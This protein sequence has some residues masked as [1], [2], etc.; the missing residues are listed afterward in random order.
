MSFFNFNFI[1]KHQ[2]FGS[3]GSIIHVIKKL[4][5]YK[6]NTRPGNSCSGVQLLYTWDNWSSSMSNVIKYR[7]SQEAWNFQVWG[8]LVQCILQ[9]IMSD[10]NIGGG[11]GGVQ[12]TAFLHQSVIP[13]GGRVG[14][15]L[16]ALDTLLH[17]VPLISHKV[18]NIQSPV[19]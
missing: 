13:T 17:F 18:M 15:P 10:L 16:Q 12:T 9:Y 2:K 4:W 3:A 7:S 8:S 14:H 6:D 11:G 1:L 19:S 5:P